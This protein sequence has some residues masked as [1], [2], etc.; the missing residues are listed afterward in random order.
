MANW[1]WVW[2]DNGQRRLI[3]IDTVA[4]ITEVAGNQAMLEWVDGNMQVIV[5]EPT[6][7]DLQRMLPC[8]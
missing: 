5:T 4:L 7:A 2:T 1:I 3:N 8:L 6:F